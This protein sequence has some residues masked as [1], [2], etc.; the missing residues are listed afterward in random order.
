MA[1]P[2][3]KRGFVGAKRAKWL[4]LG[5]ALVVISGLLFYKTAEKPAGR[6]DQ[7]VQ[8]NGSAQPL[9]QNPSKAPV[10]EQVKPQVV[11]ETLPQVAS[12]DN[13]TTQPAT[14]VTE[15]APGTD[16]PVLDSTTAEKIPELI[17]PASTKHVVP[18][19]VT[20]HHVASSSE[21]HL[22]QKK[23]ADRKALTTH[24]VNAKNHKAPKTVKMAAKEVDSDV[25]LLSA[26]VM[27]NQT[28]QTSEKS[29]LSAKSPA[30]ADSLPDTGK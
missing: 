13:T 9:E 17:P 22:S 27:H 4:V 29:K 26:L 16:Q 12:I 3:A 2:M 8:A 21:R 5:G 25:N 6:V 1:D 14:I 30:T 18:P 20:V 15:A 28:L 19:A 10:A 23:S 7:L 11:S 24:E